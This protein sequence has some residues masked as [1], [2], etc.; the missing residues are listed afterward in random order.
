MVAL[1]VMSILAL[2]ISSMTGNQQKESRAVSESFARLDLERLLISSLASGEICTFELTQPTAKTFNATKINTST[3]PIIT[4]SG[5]HASGSSAAPLIVQIGAKA[6]AS[7]ASLIVKSIDFENIVAAGTPDN[8]LADL[9]IDFDTAKSVRVLK[10]IQLRMTLV[11]DPTSPATGKK[12]VGCLRDPGSGDLWTLTPDNSGNIYYNSG[13]VAIGTANPNAAL[14]VNGGI[15]I[16]YD[17]GACNPFREGTMRYD[18]SS[19]ELQVCNGT[20]W[21]G[22]PSPSPAPAPTPTPGCTAGPA[23]VYTVASSYTD[24]CGTTYT[25]VSGCYT[26]GGGLVNPSCVKPGGSLFRVAQSGA[27]CGSGI[28]CN[29][30]NGATGFSGNDLPCGACYKRFDKP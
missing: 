9:K 21:A 4:L 14:D 19:K 3:P 20:V 24:S 13:K 27:G 6:S 7:S 23:T 2:A 8:Y 26:S 16:S 10:P 18:S 30:I 28:G 12:I 22:P 11:T 29:P 25:L 1:G 5:L 15:K 17:S